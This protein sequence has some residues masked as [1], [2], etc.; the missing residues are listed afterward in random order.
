M[1]GYEKFMIYFDLEKGLMIETLVEPFCNFLGG[2]PM[3]VSGLAILQC[4]KS[5]KL[6][7]MFHHNIT[8]DILAV[9][10]ISFFL[11]PYLPVKE[12]EMKMMMNFLSLKF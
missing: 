8:F 10:E 5:K 3:G 12:K 9:R 2:S 1:L 6:N 4:E 7:T 11:R